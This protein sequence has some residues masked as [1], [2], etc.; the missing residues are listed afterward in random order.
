MKKIFSLVLLL[1][2]AGLH[3]C[4]TDRSAKTIDPV[5]PAAIRAQLDVLRD[6]VDV[7]WR[8]MITSDD[9]QLSTTRQLLRELAAQ[10]GSDKAQ[11]EKLITANDQLKRR[12]YNQ[13]TMASSPLIDAYDTAQDSVLQAVYA[14]A[15]P[16]ASKPGS[17]AEQFTESI[18]VLASRVVGFRI[19]YDQA[20]KQYNNYLR[21]HQSDL[22]RL[23]RKYADLQPLPLFE[24]QN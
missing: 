12:R 7:N 11:L 19:H 8:R 5:S 15:R 13:Q 23:G 20:A 16:A 22:P 21:L 6:S 9:V 14:A 3:A 17:K 10:P 2:L 4:K 18:Q 24:L 1:V